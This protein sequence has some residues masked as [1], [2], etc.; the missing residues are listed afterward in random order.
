[1][2]LPRAADSDKFESG[3]GCP[4]RDFNTLS[5]KSSIW[6]GGLITNDLRNFGVEIGAVPIYY[7]AKAEAEKY[8]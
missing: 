5:G 7:P 1:M 6:T 8:A 4:R 2:F 3:L